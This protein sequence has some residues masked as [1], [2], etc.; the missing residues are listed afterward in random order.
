MTTKTIEG[1]EYEISDLP[2][3]HPY[4]FDTRKVRHEHFSD[5][6]ILRLDTQD[7]FSGKTLIKRLSNTELG[8]KRSLEGAKIV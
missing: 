1:K 6:T 7:L 8:A 2:S 4:S 3:E 5:G